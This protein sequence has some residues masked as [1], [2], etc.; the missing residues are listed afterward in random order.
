MTDV[1][2]SKGTWGECLCS[3]LLASPTW[4]FGY[5][6][7]YVLNTIMDQVNE[8]ECSGA[9]EGTQYL[10]GMA[11]FWLALGDPEFGGCISP[12][13][14][15]LDTVFGFL[16]HGCHVGTT[17]SRTT[18]HLCFFYEW[19]MNYIFDAN[20]TLWVQYAHASWI[21]MPYTYTRNGLF[22]VGGFYITMVL[23]ISVVVAF[24]M[25]FCT[26][27]SGPADAQLHL[28]RGLRASG[29]LRWFLLV[30]AWGCVQ[31]SEDEAAR[32]ALRQRAAAAATAMDP[33]AARWDWTYQ[34]Y[35]LPQPP[36][37]GYY[38]AEAH[39]ADS[40]VTWS[41]TSVRFRAWQNQDPSHSSTTY[42]CMGGS[43]RCTTSWR[44]L[45]NL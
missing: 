26:N 8:K 22:G 27:P 39:R 15:S 9:I 29:P 44:P 24:L 20:K 31:G 45:A 6:M 35:G 43:C 28:C 36:L 33:F 30:L 1:R 2:R 16:S 13:G 5:I 11:A 19:W 40:P 4:T 17:R 34:F 12:Y 18:M 23:F 21:S 3:G 38:D 25:R 41:P 10:Y 42:A 14:S 32:M 37:S 7:Y